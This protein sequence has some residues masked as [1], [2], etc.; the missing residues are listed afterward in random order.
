MTTR[1]F[2][3]INAA[4]VLFLWDRAVPKHKLREDGD[5]EGPPTWHMAVAH[6]LSDMC[7]VGLRKKGHRGVSEGPACK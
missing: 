7:H 1:K 2:D 6:T 4:G 3:V 5:G